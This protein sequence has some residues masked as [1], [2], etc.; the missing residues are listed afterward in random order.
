MDACTKYYGIVCSQKNLEPCNNVVLRE[1]AAWD[2][3][4]YESRM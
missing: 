2:I 4:T 1:S 3:T